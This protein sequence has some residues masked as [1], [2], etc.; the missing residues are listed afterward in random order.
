MRIGTELM[1]AGGGFIGTKIMGN[2]LT[3]ML[4]IAPETQPMMRIGIKAITAYLTAWGFE[5]MVGKAVFMP[6]FLG[7]AMAAVE[8]IV[9]TFITPA[10]PMLADD[11]DIYPPLVGAYPALPPGEEELVG[12]HDYDMMETEVEV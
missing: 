1:W 5:V 7:G 11:L 10:F 9:K 12:G 2:M 8:D 4:P 3:P 6:V